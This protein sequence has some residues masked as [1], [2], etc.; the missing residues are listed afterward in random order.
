MLFR[1]FYRAVAVGTLSTLGIE[2][3]LSFFSA[4]SGYDP[5]N[6]LDKWPS[7]IWPPLAALILFLVIGGFVLWVGMIWDCATANQMSVTSRVLWLILVVL[8]PYLG[9]LIYYF[10]VFKRRPLKRSQAEAKQAQV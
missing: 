1:S 4:I 9:A 2:F 8:T 6:A 5:M 3:V 7:L 10:C